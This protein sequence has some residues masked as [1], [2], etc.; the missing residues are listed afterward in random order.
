MIRV[1]MPDG[2]IRQFSG[3][4][5]QYNY[6]LSE[7]GVPIRADGSAYR[8]SSFLPNVGEVPFG[9]P[10][11]GELLDDC[12]LNIVLGQGWIPGQMSALAEQG[13]QCQ[14]AASGC[15]CCP[16][17]PNSGGPK[18][19]GAAMQ[20]GGTLEASPEPMVITRQM[21]ATRIIDLSRRQPINSIIY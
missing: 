5:V 7:G 4:S 10:G 20:T 12:P 11:S 21:Q 2:S 14:N 6:A 15:G 13:K 16:G 8:H 9:T 1:A 18:S 19:P 17:G 3:I